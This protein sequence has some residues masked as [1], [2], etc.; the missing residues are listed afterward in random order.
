MKEKTAIYI[1]TH[2]D[3]I[4][5]KNSIYKPLTV[6]GFETTDGN[7]SDNVG[8]NISDKNI[9]FRE[10][11]ALYW[12]WKNSAYEIVGLEQYKRYLCK[13]TATGYGFLNSRDIKKDLNEHDI[14]VSSKIV[15]E[16]QTVEKQYASCHNQHDYNL[17]RTMLYLMYPKY[18]ED[19]EKISSSNE[20]IPSNM[21]I[22][23]KAVLDEYCEFLFPLLFELECE[24]DVSYYDVYN[25]RVFEFLA[26]RLFN[27]WLLKKQNEGLRIKEESGC[28]LNEKKLQLI[29]K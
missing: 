2:K 9:S 26:E 4:Y 21:F 6:G 29:L 10:L 15:F 17:C 22:S 1:A 14:I 24:I 11:T 18:K 3:A 7:L 23:S 8:N 5:P 27:V 28:I 12:I 20:L 25:M 13:A 19:F 16:N